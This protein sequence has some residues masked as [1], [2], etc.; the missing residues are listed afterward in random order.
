MYKT[1][2]HAPN[3]VIIH[4]DWLFIIVKTLDIH[5]YIFCQRKFTILQYNM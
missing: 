1:I 5:T 2:T 4:Y 3:I